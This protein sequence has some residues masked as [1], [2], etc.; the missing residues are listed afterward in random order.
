LQPLLYE[1]KQREVTEHPKA[2]NTN[3]AAFKRRGCRAGVS[4]A[5]INACH[6]LR[7]ETNQNDP[8]RIKNAAVPIMNKITVAYE[9]SASSRACQSHR[10]MQ[11]KT[12]GVARRKTRAACRRL[13][14]ARTDA[15]TEAT[16][17]APTPKI[18]DHSVVRPGPTFMPAKSVVKKSPTIIPHRKTAQL[19][20]SRKGGFSQAKRLELM[21]VL[22][23]GGVRGSRRRSW[24][25]ILK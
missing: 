18:A 21:L 8:G 4:R 17:V 6:P 5:L 7:L 23:T 16:P 11:S 22:D 13:R 9:K 1:K 10:A 12:T 20:P 15:N 14:R 24:R 2:K 3:S 19:I 25:I